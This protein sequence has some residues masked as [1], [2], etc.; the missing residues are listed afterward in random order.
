MP[1]RRSTVH[2]LRVCRYEPPLVELEL[3]VSSGTY[4]RSLADA[5]GGHC[6]SLRRTAVGPF[7]VGDADPEIVLPPLAALVHLPARELADDEVRLVR[8]G[9]SLAG[10]GDGPVA[11]YHREELVAVGQAEEGAIRPETV[12]PA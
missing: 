4:V 6:R 7:R 3:L 12:L 1:V 10:E 2:K 8:S 5:V 9:R 11:L